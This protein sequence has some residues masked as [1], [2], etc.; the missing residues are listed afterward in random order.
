M[1]CI[2][3]TLDVAIKPIPT[4]PIMLAIPVVFSPRISPSN[5]KKAAV[6]AKTSPV[7]NTGKNDY[8]FLMIGCFIIS[9]LR[10]ARKTT[11]TNIRA[12]IMITGRPLPISKL[13]S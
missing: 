13:H 8:C 5:I 12:I 10:N 6:N 11:D 9:Q 4:I 3:V 7:I 2:N 1:K